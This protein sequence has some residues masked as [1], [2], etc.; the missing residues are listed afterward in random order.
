MAFHEWHAICIS[1]W[2]RG[3]EVMK[4]Q[5]LVEMRAKKQAEVV[6]NSK[7]PHFAPYSGICYSCGRQIYERLD[8]ASL[9]TG[10]PFCMISFCE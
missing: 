8:G 1:E 9:I 4:D 10:C 2:R 7:A 5:T 3:G 6:R